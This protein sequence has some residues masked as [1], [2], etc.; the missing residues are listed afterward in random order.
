MKKSDLYHIRLKRAVLVAGVLGQSLSLFM[1]AYLTSGGL[2]ESQID[3]YHAR[4][5]N[6]N[7]KCG[8]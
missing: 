6:I 7:V 4:D 2:R 3:D 5:W 8:L 1:I